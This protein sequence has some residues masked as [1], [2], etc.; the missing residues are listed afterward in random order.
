M[1]Q[2]IAEPA[3]TILY[4][5]A[6]PDL[7]RSETLAD[8]IRDSVAR[9]P[10]KVAVTLIGSDQQ[11]TYAELDRRSTKVA[12]ALAANGVKRGDF[13]GL[14]F[15][16]SIDL[17][18]AMIG[19]A[20]SGAAFIPFDADA[21]AERV[22]TSLFDCGA[23]ALVSHE[24]LVSETSKLPV[25]V[26]EL[27]TLLAM[28]ANGVVPEGPKPDSVAYAIYTSG[29]TGKPKGITITHRNI[30]H[31]LRSGNVA[32]DMRDS[33]IVFQGASVAFDLSM[34]EIWIP[35]LVGATLKVAPSEV[36]K[37]TDN[38][39]ETIVREHISVLDV[40]PTM[41]TMLDRDMPTVR[42]IITGGEAMTAALVDRWSRPGRRILNTYGPTETTVVATFAECVKGDPITIGVP[43]PNYTAYVVN[44]QLDLLGPN[45]IGELLIGG[46]G[47]AQGYINLPDM[48]AKKF[49]ANPFGSGAAGDPTLYRTGDA[50][51]IDACGRIQFHGRIDDQV[52]IRGYRIELG[53]I[54]ALIAEEAGVK[55]AAVAVHKE[56]GG[57]DVLV[58]H[59]VPAD[60]DFNAQAT[61]K[62]LVAKLPPYMVPPIW[63]THSELPRMVS[64]KID[65]KALAAMLLDMDDA[66]EPQEGARTPTEAALL[67]AAKKVFAGQ[68]IPFESDFFTDLGGHSLIAARFISTLR[69]TPAL[70]NVTLQDVYQHRTLRKLGASLDARRGEGGEPPPNL[71][72]TPP[73]FARRFW[74]GVAQ[75][76]A[77][78]FIL[79]LVTAQWIGLLLSSI[80]LVRDGTP[81]WKEVLILAAIY[82]AINMGTKF[83]VIALK[84][85]VIGR[86]RPGVYPLWGVYYFRLWVMQRIVQMTTHKFMQGTPLIRIYLRAL[87]AQIGRD[88][89][90]AEFEDGAID[91]VTIGDRTSLGAKLK[92]ANVEVVGDKV[93]VGRIT[94][95][96]DVHVGNNC[97][98]GHDVVLENGVELADLTAIPDGTT[99]RAYERWEGSPARKIGMVDK[100]TLPAHPEVSRSLKAFQAVSYFFA[101]NLICILGLLPIFPAFYI[102]YNLDSWLFSESDYMIPWSMVPVLAW[103]SAMALV[104]VSMGIAV[105][106]RW[107][108]LP[109]RVQPGVYS[110]YSGFYFRK[111]CVSLSTEVMLE[112]LNSLYATTFMRMWY[113]S[114]GSRLGKG[115]EISAA[116]GGRYDLVEMGKDNFI[117]D[118]TIFGDEDVRRGWMTLKRIK[119][120][121]RVFFGNSSV[122]A[123]GAVIEDGA[124]IGV[125]SRLPNSLHVKK[126]ETW[127][128]SPPIQ[129]PVRQKIELGAVWTYQP[130]LRMKIWRAVFE[131]MHTSMPTALLITAAYITGDIIAAPIE[132]KQWG[133]AFA[134]F[135]SAG[136]VI[137]LIQYAISVINKWVLMGRY[138][139]VM[140]PMWSWWA[141]RTEAV[142]VFYGGLAG[143]AYLEYLRGTPFLP[144][145]LRAYGTKIGKGA[146]INWTDVTEFDCI[147]IGDFASVNMHVC[148]QT[149]LYEDRVMKVGVINIGKGVTIGTGSTILYDAK[150]ED[151]AQLG[152]LTLVMKGESIPE[153]S[154]WAGAPAQLVAARKLDAAPDKVELPSL[155]TAA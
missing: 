126:G 74:C 46:P 111:W 115:T 47:V 152:P 105:I 55:A 141:M 131:A 60:P 155:A 69:E 42:L 80:F 25:T 57:G 36:L 9:A 16:R 96:S 43:I 97:V 90:I 5:G 85:L 91:L 119:T 127:F 76:V 102:L 77:L 89:L 27:D 79:A 48:T 53:E 82:V 2:L 138:R 3:T 68:A 10:D 123:Q 133:M 104:F 19:I 66:S 147:R 144:W 22:A 37:D 108:L 30:A 18:V 26:L 103:P 38:L 150:I 139:P 120:G 125:K 31:Y 112:T 128:G 142:A 95:G 92:L 15:R 33:D 122:I 59:V 49:I 75:A 94:I 124:L 44:E 50:V 132:E 136:I 154:R 67:A 17:H 81:L 45:E 23:K 134:V 118:E 65:R 117:G 1:N 137:G 101:Y 114:M 99:V 140:K 149:H 64:G 35:Y 39:P 62:A 100:D 121:D 21:P 12:S 83:V 146:W 88:T 116:F 93:H 13:V 52:K 87:G 72:F 11:L 84:W 63:R 86:T 54:E 34:E 129:L 20:K 78:P 24:A 41:L 145:F 61:K 58:A 8:I 153:N 40:V 135:I 110:I 107:L 109:R 71:R 130:P 70:A 51:S 6:R 151:W 28:P 73:S 14:W 29:S 4:G 148:P 106:F 56:G 32:I 98:I 7:L 113:S 143:K